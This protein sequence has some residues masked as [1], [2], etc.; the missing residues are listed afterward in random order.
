MAG[1]VNVRF[2]GLTVSLHGYATTPLPGLTVALTGV[3]RQPGTVAAVLPGL[4]VSLTGVVV[5]SVVG[6]PS[7]ILP[8]LQVALTGNVAGGTVRVILPGLSVSLT[9]LTGLVGK[10][11]VILPGMTVSLTGYVIPVGVPAVILPGLTVA[12][13]GTVAAAS[14]KAIVINT[15]TFAISEYDNFNFSSFARYNGAVYASGPAGL[16]RLDG[17]LDDTTPIGAKLSTGLWSFDTTNNV[18]LDDMIAYLKGS[19]VKITTVDDE[20]NP[21]SSE[22]TNQATKSG[23]YP[24]R[25]TACKGGIG[26]AFGFDIENVEGGDLELKDLEVRVEKLRRKW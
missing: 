4:Q 13:K 3:T 25:L 8:G 17:A 5:G 26:N 18:R 6:Y 1:T 16:Y 2:P 23:V 19:Q 9:G 7:V 20:L 12:L 24:V 22:I 10:P 15:E 14:Y 11:T 21:T